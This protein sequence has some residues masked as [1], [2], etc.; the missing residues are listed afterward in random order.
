MIHCV[1]VKKAPQKNENKIIR[2]PTRHNGQKIVSLNGR[3]FPLVV[4]SLNVKWKITT[5]SPESIIDC[6][7]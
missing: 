1:R 7:C 5:E 3:E 4:N 2:T 6:L